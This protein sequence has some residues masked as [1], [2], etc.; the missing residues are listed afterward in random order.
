MQSAGLP[1]RRIVVF[2]AAT[3]RNLV[4][5]MKAPITSPG[6]WV[7]RRDALRFVLL[8]AAAGMA[9]ILWGLFDSRLVFPKRG[10][11]NNGVIRM[12]DLPGPGLPGWV[13]VDARD[14]MLYRMGHIPGAFNI[15]ARRLDVPA[16][17]LLAMLPPDIRGTPVLVYCSD[18]DCE[19]SRRVAELLRVAGLARVHV[20]MEGWRGWR[21]AGREVEQP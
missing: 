6:A 4:P 21:E 8:A 7:I 18:T 20:L 17:E 11:G 9:G 3:G 15:P 5:D 1:V 13:V 14:P 16:Q 2:S 10:L 12:V 19:D